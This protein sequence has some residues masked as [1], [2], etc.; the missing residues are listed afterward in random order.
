MACTPVSSQT[1][2]LVDFAATSCPIVSPINPIS[3]KYFMYCINRKACYV[4]HNNIAGVIGSSYVAHETCTS[5]SFLTLCPV[6]SA[7]HLSD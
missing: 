7:C 4:Y 6:N 1:L 3:R 2:C 5:A